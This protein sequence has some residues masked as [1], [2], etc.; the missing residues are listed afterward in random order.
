MNGPIRRLDQV[1]RTAKHLA[2]RMIASYFPRPDWGQIIAADPDAWQAARAAAAGGRRVLIATSTGG[3]N[4]ITPIESVLGAA[5]TMR[6]AAV[7]FLLCDRFLP[8]CLQATYGNGTTAPAMARLGPRGAGLC[9][10]CFRAGFKTYAP[11]GLPIHRY[12]ALVSAEERAEAARLAR[13][14]PLDAIT[15]FTLDGLAVGEHAQAGALRYFARGDLRGEPL[16]E[17][18]LRRY[19]E[20]AVLTVFATR[21]LI[22]RERIEVAV[23][24][25][26]IYVPQGLIGEVCRQ[27]GVRVVTWATAYR[28]RSFIFSHDDTYHHTLMDEPTTAWEDL[29]WSEALEGELLDYLKSRWQGSRD[30]IFFHEK[31]KED[32][33]LIA[34]EIGID[35]DRPTIGLLTNVIWD[36]QLHY[37]ANAFPGMLDWILRTIDYFAR[38]PE[39]QLLI[40]VH[41]AEIRGGVPSR[42]LVADEVRRAYPTLP[43]NVFLIGPESQVS[44]YAAMLRC[45]SVIIYGTKTGVELS[46]LGVPVIV[47][48]EAWIRGKGVTMDA[49]SVEEYMAI[50]DGLPLGRGLDAPT[51]RRARMYAYHF[52]FRRMVPV[53]MVEPTVPGARGLRN[54]WPYDLR[55]ARVGDLQAGRD[56]G[57]DVICR[58]ILEGEPFIFPAERLEH[59]SLA[60]R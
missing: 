32:L 54:W 12:S 42:Q 13:T 58:G 26:G 47:A 19:L 22:D 60:I 17:P 41:P 33:D 18:I 31:P 50:L 9:G 14:L 45:D 10:T 55:V 20:A 6:G 57:L 37:P 36:A 49:G 59:A 28:K 51:T 52:F 25:H 39:L 44:T 24:H 15:G 48:G 46:S 43:P 5:L 35:L 29:D 40:R 16:G 1:S 8:A 30:W 2:A 4:A 56:P 27:K 21:R 11:L 3:H 38:R 34:R 53:S 7:H 23:I